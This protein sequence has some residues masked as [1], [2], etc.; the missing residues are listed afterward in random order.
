MSSFN[1]FS[2]FSNFGTINTLSF[3]MKKEIN[4]TTKFI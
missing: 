3:R 4:I 2:S 1:S